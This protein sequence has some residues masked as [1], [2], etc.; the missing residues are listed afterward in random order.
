MLKICQTVDKFTTRYSASF[1]P[2]IRG[3]SHSNTCHSA[4]TIIKISE[5]RLALN[6]NRIF[7]INVFSYLGFKDWLYEQRCVFSLIAKKSCHWNIFCCWNTFSTLKSFQVFLYM[8]QIALGISGLIISDKF[9]FEVEFLRYMFSGENSVWRSPGLDYLGVE[10][11]L[12][13]TTMGGS[14]DRS[15]RAATS[16]S[17]CNCT[18]TEDRYLTPV[19]N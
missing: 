10:S 6:V 7:F 1:L 19:M 16:S 15:L 5:P 3:D 9:V 13:W 11:V 17:S 4:S 8:I 14:E 18:E 12:I 2:D